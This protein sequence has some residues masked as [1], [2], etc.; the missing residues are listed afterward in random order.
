MSVGEAV[1]V[2]TKLTIG[3]GLVSQIPAFIVSLAAGLIVTR[4]SGKSNLGE[5]MI[6]QVLAKPK[7]LIIAAAF[8]MLAN[9]FRN[10]RRW[11][12]YIAWLLIA[13]L[14]LTRRPA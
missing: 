14:A 5:D 9:F 13:A 12:L 4:T 3:D 11:R 6:A 7:A 10:L 8:L 2:F 1:N